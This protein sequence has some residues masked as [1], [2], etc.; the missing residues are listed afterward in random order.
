MNNNRI[1]RLPGKMNVINLIP[2]FMLLLSPLNLHA[3]IIQTGNVNEIDGVK[4]LDLSVTSGLSLNQALSSYDGFRVASNE[5]F[6]FMFSSFVD[7]ND[8]LFV[9]VASESHTI[10]SKGNIRH[11]NV[12]GNTY[13]NSF[14]DTFGLTDSL[15]IA[16]WKT[17]YTSLGM[18]ID[19]DLLFI[20]G[21][22]RIIDLNHPD[23]ANEVYNYVGGFSNHIDNPDLGFNNIGWYMVEESFAL[24]DE[25]SILV[26]FIIGIAGLGF[27]RNVKNQVL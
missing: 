23:T 13:S 10:D 3:T 15:R 17:N 26:L 4:W 7:P 21:V 8:Q 19:D 20:G 2:L 14:F 25:P 1:L 12:S 24:V 5:E 22:T 11:E 6:N 27:V 16:S 18:Y 9:D